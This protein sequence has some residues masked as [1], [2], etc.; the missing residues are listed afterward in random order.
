[1]II[2]FDRPLKYEKYTVT[3]YGN[4]TNAVISKETGEKIDGD[5]NGLAGG[6]AAIVLQHRLRED[7]DNDDTIHMIDLSKLA[8]KWLWS[9]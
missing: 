2:T 4:E 8:Q 3:I 7:L 9:E 5:N 1:M 6:D